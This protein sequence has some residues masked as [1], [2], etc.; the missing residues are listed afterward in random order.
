MLTSCRSVFDGPMCC[1][2]I[3]RFVSYARDCICFVLLRYERKEHKPGGPLIRK[4]KI[5]IIHF[6][7]SF[8]SNANFKLII[9]S[10]LKIGM[11]NKMK[12][13]PFFGFQN[14]ILT[15]IPVLVKIIGDL[16]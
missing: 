9:L 3:L 7:P 2:V 4:R 12:I 16:S 14:K 11:K 1:N 10:R 15:H 5:S 6:F 13:K 8:S